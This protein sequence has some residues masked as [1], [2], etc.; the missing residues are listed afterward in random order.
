MTINRTL[1]IAEAGVNHN[2]NIELAKQLIDAAAEA[3]ADL[4]KFQT[5]NAKRQVTSFAKKAEYQKMT[6]NSEESQY[7]MLRKLELSTEMHYDLINHCSSCNIGFFSTGFDI[8][9]I[10]FLVNLGQDNF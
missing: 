7:E 10:N 3:G 2:G 4:V 1:I 9:S 8:D 5:F 6:T